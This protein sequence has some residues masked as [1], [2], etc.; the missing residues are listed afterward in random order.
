MTSNPC[1]EITN[2][3]HPHKV[4]I[5]YEKIDI[6]NPV[7]LPSI[8]DALSEYFGIHDYFKIKM[9]SKSWRLAL[10]NYVADVKEPFTCL[11]NA[12]EHDCQN[13][14]EQLSVLEN[15]TDKWSELLLNGYKYGSLKCMELFKDKFENLQFNNLSLLVQPRDCTVQHIVFIHNCILYALSHDINKVQKLIEY[16]TEYYMIEHYDTLKLI[17]DVANYQIIT[18]VIKKL[19]NPHSRTNMLILPLLCQLK[20]IDKKISKYIDY[21]NYE[22]IVKL[23][24]D[25]INIYTKEIILKLLKKLFKIMG[26]FYNLT[27]SDT[28]IEIIIQWLFEVNTNDSI[29][30]RMISLSNLKD[31]HIKSL[32]YK[33]YET[34]NPSLIDNYLSNTIPSNLLSIELAI[35]Y[36]K[37]NVYVSKLNFDRILKLIDET[38][39]IYT[40]EQLILKLKYFND[41]YDE[42]AKRMIEWVLKYGSDDLVNHTIQLKLKDELKI[43]LVP[44]Y[45]SIKQKSIGLSR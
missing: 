27:I 17:C 6:Y 33:I 21:D 32:A 39:H 22:K 5:C 40:K 44:R 29:I 37:G 34:K 19:Q 18:N 41:I 45:Y 26:Q 9:V 31:K 1:K 35:K 16:I 4:N 3:F 15:F 12:I 10:Q 42:F 20:M 43:L 11:L 2:I 38:D 14:A 7:S 13:C 36:S 24:V 8:I 25:N 28:Y 23:T 30:I